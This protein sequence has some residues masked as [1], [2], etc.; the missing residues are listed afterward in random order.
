MK[1][2][3]NNELMVN[4]P[5]ILEFFQRSKYVLTLSK[6]SNEETEIHLRSE[7]EWIALQQIIKGRHTYCDILDKESLEYFTEYIEEQNYLFTFYI[8]NHYEY[9]NVLEIMKMYE[10]FDFHEMM[11]VPDLQEYFFER[12]LYLPNR[13][14]ISFFP[15]LNSFLQHKTKYGR[16][17]F[18]RFLR[19]FNEYSKRMKWL[20]KR[21]HHTFDSFSPFYLQK[22][23]SEDDFAWIESML[24]PKELYQIM[25]EE[26]DSHQ[27]ICEFLQL[28]EE[29]SHQMKELFESN[30]IIFAGSSLM[31]LTLRDYPVEMVNDMDIWYLD[32]NGNNSI[33]Q[34][35][36]KFQNIMDSPMNYLM[37]NNGILNLNFTEKNRKIQ[38]LH[39][40]ER[41]GYSIIKNFDF[42][43]VRLFLQQR[44]NSF[45]LTTDFCESIIHKKLY[46]GYDVSNMVRQ[47]TYIVQRRI[48]KYQ[49][50]GFEL[51]PY[52]QS[53]VDDYEPNLKIDEL[54]LSK[55]LFDGKIGCE[56]LHGEGKVSHKM[57]KTYFSQNYFTLFDMSNYNSLSDEGI[58]N[59]Y[60]YMKIKPSIDIL[61]KNHSIFSEYFFTPYF[62][63]MTNYEKSN[64]CN[65]IDIISKHYN[66]IDCK[67]F[68][69]LYPKVHIIDYLTGDIFH[70]FKAHLPI[71]IEEI[72]NKYEL[73][74]KK[75]KY[76]EYTIYV[77]YQS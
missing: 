3:V 55:K 23:Y 5:G 10:G 69:Y 48:D 63:I 32:K 36:D 22:R 21:I 8:V 68:D 2:Y 42:S 45:I 47:F 72:T 59:I 39:V 6:I 51:S 28:N 31:Y 37:K 7:R 43:C 14:D 52:L 60:D 56:F 70:Y 62:E 67:S 4:S 75:M 74:P 44:K 49:K 34:F 19:V 66:F 64:I 40:L 20:G 26:Y 1:I 76:D 11:R 27:K 12:A 18:Y 13:R 46:D 24:F 30:T 71:P 65:R 50:R 54:L 77:N 16:D 25:D 33:S 17:D 41:D 53:I 38:L 35:T 73:D 15:F 61:E 57:L 58:H 9:Q 29:K